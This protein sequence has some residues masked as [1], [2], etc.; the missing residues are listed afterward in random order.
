MAR[1]P[2]LTPFGDT[3][4]DRPLRVRAEDLEDLT[5]VAAYLQDAIVPV[6]EM[7]FEAAEN[8]FVL[9]AGRFRWEIAPDG[10]V[11]EGQGTPFERVHTGIRFE[12]VRKVRTRGIDR[13]DPGQ[14][15]NLLS[16]AYADG[17]VDLVFAGDS[18]IRLDVDGLSC[19]VE[20]LGT[21]WPTVFRPSH[22]DG[23]DK[24]GAPK[25]D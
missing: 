6:S 25:V 11:A 18:T 14:M 2:A 9:V 22:D 17:T 15:L 10:K 3:G 4:R 24:D 7:S 1:R 23:D 21:P 16:L 12:R 5:V 19:H 20:D 8:R 13:R